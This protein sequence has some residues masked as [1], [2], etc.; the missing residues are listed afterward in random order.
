MNLRMLAASTAAIAFA[1]TA[2]NAATFTANNSREFAQ[3]ITQVN[4]GDTIRLAPGN[5]GRVYIEGGRYNK[6]AIGNN[7]IRKKTPSLSSN[8]FIE[9]MDPNN[10]ATFQSIDVR[11]SDYWSFDSVDVRPGPQVEWYHAVNLGGNNLKFTN[12]SVSYGDATNWNA[13][14]WRNKA[15]RGVYVWGDDAVVQNNLMKNVSVGVSLDHSAKN[16]R[17]INNTVDGI[18]RDGLRGLGD[19]GLFENNLV[20]NFKAVS[21]NHDDCFQSFSKKNGRIGAGEVVGVTL[22]GNVCIASEDPNDPLYSPA[23]GYLMNNGVARDWV[24]EDNVYSSSAYHGIRV[25]RAENVTVRNNTVI[26]DQPWINGKDFVWILIDSIHS[27]S[28]APSLVENN[29]A[30]MFKS[31]P[32]TAEINNHTISIDEYD[33]WFVDWRNGD[34]TLKSTAP[35]FGVGA[36]LAQVGATSTGSSTPSTPTSPSD[37]SDPTDPIGGTPLG[38]PTLLSVQ[39][40]ST[41][42]VELPIPVPASGLMAI[43]GV[44]A[45]AGLRLRNKR[46]QNAAA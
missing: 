34:F 43:S 25:V 12:S 37:P 46:K 2:A 5:Y 44:L 21:S 30:N 40:A 14:D 18:S 6:V 13:S 33:T 22:R 20:K 39:V 35:I 45:L 7:W 1:A 41:S 19:F 10:R 23:Q 28:A 15:G 32:N 36:T 24:I 16:G 29:L 8:V 17:V 26:D 11:G 27:S 31:G 4:D 38:F 42:N 9:S 3:A